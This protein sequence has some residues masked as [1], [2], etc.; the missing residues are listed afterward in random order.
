MYVILGQQDDDQLNI[1]AYITQ[2]H[3]EMCV[4]VLSAETAAA[5]PPV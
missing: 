4:C 3:S 1:R 2:C 5:L